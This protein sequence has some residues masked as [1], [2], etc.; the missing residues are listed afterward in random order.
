MRK[1][2]IGAACSAACAL[3]SFSAAHAAI[4][5]QIWTNEVGAAT[6]AT[7]AQAASL[8]TPDETATV[9][10]IDF[11]AVP[12]NSA[13]STIAQFLNNPADL[14]ASVGNLTLNNS[15]F[16]FTGSTFLQAG[17]NSFV[18]PHDDGL[19]L[20][21]TG[22]G[23]VVDQPGPTAEVLTPFDV[24]A[25]SAGLYDFTLSY[26]ECCAGPAVLAFQV[27]GE[28]VGGGVIPEPATWAMMILGF[29]GVGVLLR[30]RR[31]LLAA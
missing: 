14:D 18:V 9:G 5:V 4:T 16:L 13:V 11:R 27:N 24:V 3:L 31:E 20:T 25:P 7:I 1:Q 26:G 6:N 10:A 28:P 2:L 22:I 23:M 15:Y 30:R 19:Q 17:T 29:G 12:A 21:I 8:G